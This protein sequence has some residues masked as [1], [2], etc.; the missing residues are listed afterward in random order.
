MEHRESSENEQGRVSHAEISDAGSAQELLQAQKAVWD[1]PLGSAPSCA[2]ITELNS[3]WKK[4]Q[5]PAPI[6][7]PC[8]GGLKGNKE[9]KWTEFREC[10]LRILS[11]SIICVR[12]I[13]QLDGTGISFILTISLR[14]ETE[15]LQYGRRNRS[16]KFQG[17]LPKSCSSLG[18]TVVPG[19][20]EWGCEAN[21][22]QDGFESWEGSGCFPELARLQGKH[23]TPS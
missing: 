12:R 22:W 18:H 1:V 21:K 7:E 4:L 11:C 2:P 9:G 19:N 15:N 20:T 14:R 10:I 8:Q 16:R 13:T 3:V 23:L 6:P 17:T 5:Y